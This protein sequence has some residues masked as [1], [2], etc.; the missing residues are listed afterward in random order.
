MP[1]PSMR[2]VIS[3]TSPLQYLH[4]IR[5]LALLKQLYARVIVPQ[6]V[7]DELDLGRQ[8]GFDEP[9]CRT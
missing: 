3:N 4:A 7:V 8:Q 2:R 1:P 5:Q 6:A 9:D